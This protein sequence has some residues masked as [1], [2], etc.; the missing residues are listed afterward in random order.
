VAK[1]SALVGVSVNTWY[2]WESSFNDPG[3]AKGVKITTA[4]GCTLDEVIEAIEPTISYPKEYEFMGEH[5][6][7]VTLLVQLSV[8]ELIEDWVDYL[9][10]IGSYLNA[11]ITPRRRGRAVELAIANGS[12]TCEGF[13]EFHARKYDQ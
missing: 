13:A 5:Y 9:E 12:A 6:V 4:L 2:R 7:R 1:V 3:I 8:Y 10:S 11:E